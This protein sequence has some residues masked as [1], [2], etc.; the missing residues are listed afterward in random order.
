ML[1]LLIVGYVK[2]E[3]SKLMKLHALNET[4]IHRFVQD[5]A[6]LKVKRTTTP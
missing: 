2:F 4:N 6:M 5:L 3:I 1:D